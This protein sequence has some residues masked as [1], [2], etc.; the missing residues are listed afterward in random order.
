MRP[1]PDDLWKDRLTKWK[2]ILVAVAGSVVLARIALDL[3]ISN[4]YG[5]GPGQI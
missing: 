4:P 3:A 5:A 1:Y 2:P